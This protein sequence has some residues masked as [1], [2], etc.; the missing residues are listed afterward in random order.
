MVIK[1]AEILGYCM[2]VRRAVETAELAC[3]E[4]P[5]KKIFTLGPLIHNNSALEVLAE[6]G[7]NVLKEDASD[8]AADADNSVVI[9]RAHGVPPLVMEN[10]K[11][12]GVTVIDATCP[13]VLSSQKRAA[14]YA[15]RGY[16][17]FLAGDKNH[18]EVVGISGYARASGADCIVIEH[19]EDAAAVMHVPEKSVLLSQTTI[20][21]SEYDAI[22]AVLKAKND[23]LVVLNTICPATDE[24]QNALIE[25]CKNVDGILVIGGKHS[26]NTKRLLRT[27]QDL[28]AHAALI[29]TAE[30]IPQEFFA[31]ERIGLTAGASTPDF[32]IDSVETALLEHPCKI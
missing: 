8:L 16:T 1:K 17:V 25:L 23:A 11:S 20:S 3:R 30:E 2:G 19:K 4:N 14:D 32:V 13:R 27:A 18:G 24:R 9:V 12:R 5:D 6:K 22:A 26:A 31:L 21:R 29:E 10:L 15:R 7:V 28:C